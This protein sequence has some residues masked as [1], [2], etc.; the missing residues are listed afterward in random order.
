MNEL[1]LVLK[2]G[3]EELWAGES[4]KRLELPLAF[5]RALSESLRAAGYPQLAT[6]VEQ[7]VNAAQTRA[8]LAFEK[9]QCME[10][11]YDA[12]VQARCRVL[13]DDDLKPQK[14]R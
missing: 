7:A 13:L 11:A 3:R 9:L 12:Q 1:E 5:W 2:A 8:R 6:A 4:G 14:N 10:P